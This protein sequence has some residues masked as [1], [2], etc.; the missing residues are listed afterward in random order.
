ME[1]LREIETELSGIAP[2]LGKNGI[3]LPPY[4]VPAGYFEHFAEGLLQKIREEN[5]DT[6]LS[7]LSPLLAGIERRTPYRVPDQY[8]NEFSAQTASSAKPKASIIAL[9]SGSRSWM[10]YAAAAILTGAIATATFFSFHKTNSDPLSGL[11][12]M[13]DQE[14][15]SYLE[16]QDVHWAPGTST[17]PTA[18]ID[19]DD[20][21]IS[22]LLSN[23]SDA[24]LEQYLPDLPV[25]KRTIN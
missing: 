18:S 16:N 24:E 13:S 7:A 17:T 3:T 8:F 22:D 5:P 20:N 25:K 21:D 2:V 23:V 14:M 12:K 6:E 19:F 9:R 10:R 4:R 11:N 1:R 15:A